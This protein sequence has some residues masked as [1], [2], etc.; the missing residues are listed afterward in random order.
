MFRRSGSVIAGLA[1][2][3]PADL[4]GQYIDFADERLAKYQL[5]A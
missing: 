1:V 4:S 5:G 2:D 3:G